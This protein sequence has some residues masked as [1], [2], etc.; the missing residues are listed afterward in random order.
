MPEDEHEEDVRI[1]WLHVKKLMGDQESKDIVRTV[2]KDN[3]LEVWR[4]LARR[5]APK[6]AATKSRELRQITNYAEKH[7]NTPMAKVLS[8]IAAFEELNRNYNEGY[9]V[10][11]L[12]AE[13]TVDAIK[14]IIP[15]EIERS[16]NLNLIGRPEP[17]YDE[18]KELVTQYIVQNTPAPM[19]VG[20]VGDQQ[21]V[22]GQSEDI[23]SLGYAEINS[24]FDS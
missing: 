1:A 24:R 12:T 22:E 14:C 19:D 15:A 21:A 5:Y 23:S 3:G 20:E 13:L 2:P 8:V 9:K 17:T 11:P 7:E 4:L 18:L 6:T 10:H 16:I